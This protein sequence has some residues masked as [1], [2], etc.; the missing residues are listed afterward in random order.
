M[1]MTIGNKPLKQKPD[2]KHE[3]AKYFK[4][5]KFK[6]GNF[7][8]ESIKKIIENG[9]TITYL[10]NDEEFSREEGYMSNNYLGTQFFCIDIDKCDVPPSEFVEHVKYR[11]SVLHTTFSNLTEVKENKYC[12]HMLYFFDTI[13]YGED[14]FHKVFNILT[15][16]MSYVDDRAKDCHRVMYSSNSSL[17]NYE[18]YDYNITYKVDEFIKES[19]DDVENL[20]EV[21]HEEWDKIS[22]ADI[23]NISLNNISVETKMSQDSDFILDKEFFND[24]YSMKRSEFIYHYSS[25][26]PFI[27]ETYI[28]PNRYE[29]G[30]VDLRNENYYVVP[31][32]QYRWDSEKQKPHIPKIQIGH[33]NTMLWLDA[34]C[35]MKIVPNISKEHFVYMLTTE[36]YRNFDNTDHQLT[37]QYIITK[38]KEV[39]NSADKNNPK[40]VRK[41]FKI[42]KNY[43]LERGMDNWLAIT[44]EIRKQIKCEDFESLY[45]FSMTID[46]NIREFKNYGVSTTS[47]TLKT[48]LEENNI[49]YKTD[50]QVR[51]EHVIK[52]YEEDTSRSSRE[53]ETL[54]KEQGVNISY[55]TIQRILTDYK[56]Q[57]M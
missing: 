53:I 36:V 21:R 16:N 38:C 56:S 25:T 7:N 34:C 39:W 41:S 6:T 17:E 54:C 28:D 42:D 8:N 30:Y 22:V 33:R 10:Y 45:D 51:N 13:I 5:I 35:F 57:H 37:N 31:S 49:P 55:R 1:K 43:W 44:N 18:Y 9:Y 46:Q 11:P 19:Y 26:Y 15:E 52:L 20:F 23:S 4:D 40:P 47:R 24:M 32:A 2:P 3:A 50:K 48:W 27:T 12:F 29:N 14:N